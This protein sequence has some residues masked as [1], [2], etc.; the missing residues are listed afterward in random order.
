MGHPLSYVQ[1]KNPFAQQGF[2]EVSLAVVGV[3][4]DTTFKGN[5]MGVSVGVGSGSPRGERSRKYKQGRGLSLSWVPQRTGRAPRA[6]TGLQ[7][8]MTRVGTEQGSLNERM[9][10]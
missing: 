8:W 5:R 7:H 2:G 1:R 3:R 4:V 9:H 10:E 6:G